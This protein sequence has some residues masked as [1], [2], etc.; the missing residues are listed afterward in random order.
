MDRVWERYDSVLKNLMWIKYNKMK[1]RG[2]YIKRGWVDI[3]I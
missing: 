2:S 1:N 3:I